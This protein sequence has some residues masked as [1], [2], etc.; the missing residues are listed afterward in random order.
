MYSCKCDLRCC[1]LVLCFEIKRHQSIINLPTSFMSPWTIKIYSQ[2]SDPSFN[3]AGMLNFLIPSFRW[4]SQLPDSWPYAMITTKA[5]T[6][7]YQSSYYRTWHFH[8]TVLFKWDW[9]KEIR[10]ILLV[11]STSKI[12]NILH[13]VMP[14]IGTQVI[15]R[16][17]D[18]CPF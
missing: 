2:A 1:L 15:W 5:Q 16:C 11:R 12:I 14:G 17:P 10:N 4:W 8:I 6:N 7:E 3:E 13:Q 18:T 9:L